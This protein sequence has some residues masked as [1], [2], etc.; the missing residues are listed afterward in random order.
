MPKKKES[1]ERTYLKSVKLKGYKSIVD[2]EI[3]LHKE[4]NI[5]I[6]KNAAGKTNFLEFL[7]KAL[8]GDFRNMN[9]FTTSLSFN[10]EYTL[11]HKRKLKSRLLVEKKIISDEIEPIV[12]KN[13]QEL[14]GKQ[15]EKAINIIRSLDTVKI[16]HGVPKKYDI[17]SEPFEF[18]LEKQDLF[19][20]FILEDDFNVNP[21]S[22]FFFEFIF[23]IWRQILKTDKDLITTVTL[24]ERILSTFE[25]Y[26][27][28]KFFLSKLTPIEDIRISENL[29]IFDGKKQ[30]TVSNL[31]LEFKVEGYWHPFANLSD[32]TKRLFYIISEVVG[33]D[34]SRYENRIVFIEEPELGIH[35][36]QLHDMMTFLKEMS[37]TR[38]IIITTHSPQV[39]NVLEADELDQIII[40]SSKGQ[41]RGTI[42]KHLTQTEKEK[43][44]SYMEDMYL[45]DYW[46]Y[47]DLED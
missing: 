36:H 5:I 10:G 28:L 24:S 17:A 34:E 26:S 1:V 45:S 31:F 47:S 8:D 12:Y 22:E 40:A 44:Q 21:V 2:V 23:A 46:L 30:W 32:G 14:F 38:Q 7:D 41:E 6:G 13:Q 18:K 27:K 19:P 25:D 3:D 35:P 29:N 39:L 42:L 9:D 37:K 15:R 16:D 11:F 20:S 4:L 43:A 33:K